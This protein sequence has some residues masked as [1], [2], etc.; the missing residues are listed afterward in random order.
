MEVRMAITA[1]L[2]SLNLPQLDCEVMGNLYCINK[3]TVFKDLLLILK[4]IA[5]FFSD[6]TT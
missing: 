1:S 5:W 2:G 4:F 6:A 3:N